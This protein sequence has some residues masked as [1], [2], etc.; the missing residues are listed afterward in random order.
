MLLA[1]MALMGAAPAPALSDTTFVVE[2][3][4]VL[5]V[6]RVDGR[7]RIQ[8]VDGDRVRVDFEREDDEDL[9]IRRRDRRA[10][11]AIP[12][13]SSGR[14]IVLEVPRWMEVSLEIDDGGLHVEGLRNE[15]HALVGDG[16]VTGRDLRGQIRIQAIDGR[17]ELSEVEGRVSVE[18]ADDD[19]EITGARGSFELNSIDGHIALVDVDAERLEVS[20]VDGSLRFEGSLTGEGESS[21]TTHDGNVTVVLRDTPD[22]HV[23][24]LANDGYIDTEFP[25]SL[26][27]QHDSFRIEFEIG[28]GK[29]QLTLRAFEGNISIAEM[30]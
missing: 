13:G 26:R 1:L 29:P 21:L 30:R 25:S 8:G 7:V 27:R 3:G 5:R 4:Q 6:L 23:V 9:R 12:D 11:L 16:P 10:S 20:T 17:V 15:I 22:L 28:T 18:S 24:G 19:I 2:R 14:D